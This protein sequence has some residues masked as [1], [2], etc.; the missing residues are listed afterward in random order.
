MPKLPPI[1][2]LAGFKRWIERQRKRRSGLD[3]LT[4]EPDGEDSQDSGALSSSSS[5]MEDSCS[6]DDSKAFSGASIAQA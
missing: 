5:S 2:E 1:K 6:L 4:F 3:V